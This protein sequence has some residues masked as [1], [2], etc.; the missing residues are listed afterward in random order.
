M[1]STA[2]AQLDA[3]MKTRL[4]HTQHSKLAITL[5]DSKVLGRITEMRTEKVRES[6]K[7]STNKMKTHNSAWT[8]VI[9]KASNE[10]IFL[11]RRDLV[12]HWFD[13][14]T[15]SQR[16]RFFDL[17]FRQCSR[18]QYKFV[19]DWFEEMV[20]LQHLDFTTVLPRFLA[21]Y[22]F[23]FLEPKSLSRCAQV[24]WHW[25]F[26]SE[27]D[28]LWMPKC[29]KYGWFLPY[30]PAMHEYGSWKRHYVGC[31]LTLD[32]VTTNSANNA[33]YGM[34]GDGVDLM[35]KQ[36]SQKDL[37]PAESYMMVTSRPPWIAP[38]SHPKDL[39]KNMYAFLHDFNPND[40]S[41]PKSALLFHNRWGILKKK[42]NVTTSLSTELGLNT[43]RRRERHR[44]LTSGE[45]YDLQ[46]GRSMTLTESMKDDLVNPRERRVNELVNTQWYPQYRTGP[47]SSAEEIVLERTDMSG[48]KATYRDTMRSTRRSSLAG[49]ER[50][51]N[52]RVIFISSRV[53]A[54]ELLLDAVLFGVVPIVYEYEGTTPESLL[55]RLEKALQGRNA[56]SIGIFTHTES[57]GEIRL[58][59]SCN[60]SLANMDYPEAREFFEM[61]SGHILPSGMGGQF[62]IFAPLAASEL[63]MELMVQLTVL[64]GVQFS[65]PTGI[66]G[67]YN[68]VSSDW[69]IPY[70][71]GPPP[72]QYF[73]TSKLNVWANTADQAVES[74]K[75]CRQILAPYFENAHRDVAAQLT[76]EVVF[77]VLGQTDIR[78][79]KS[80]TEALTEALVALGDQNGEN[81]LEFLGQY[82][83][84][85]AGVSD[86]EF[87]STR[88]RLPAIELPEDEMQ[89]EVDEEGTDKT[90]KADAKKP[91]DSVWDSDNDDIQGG[92]DARVARRGED[93][94]EKGTLEGTE[95]SEK[96][97]RTRQRGERQKVVMKTQELSKKF[98]TI[99]ATGKLERLTSHRFREYPEKRTPIAMEIVSSEVDYNRAL[100][101][102]KKV[103][104]KPLNAAL[105]SNR[106]IISNQN[107]QI[108]FTDILAI[109]ENSSELKDNLQSRLLDWDPQQSCLGDIFVKFNSHLKVYTNFINNNEVILRCIERSKE[110]TPA[111]RAFLARHD[112][113]PETKMLTLQ[114][115]LLLPGCR[116]NQYV[117]LLSWFELHTPK[118]HQDRADLANA[119]ETLTELDRCIR[120]CQ[121][122][123]ERDRELIELQRK[124]LNC[125][126]LLEANRYLVKHLDVNQHNPPKKNSDIPELQFFQTAATYGLFLF[127]DALVLTRRTSKHFP[128]SRAIEHNY[129]FEASISLGRLRIHDMPDSKDLTNSFKME[130]PKQ[131]WYFST[132]TA[133]EKHNWVSL[134]EQS[135]RSHLQG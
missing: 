67:N 107:L 123:M 130:N 59:H 114:E 26:L 1:T 62:D 49:T 40:P 83:L 10:Q 45:D 99:R 35:A 82:L 60:V 51:Q 7:F 89:P 102:V 81:P 54:A 110:Q 34:R 41:M 4:R 124:I 31:V 11:E 42:S 27:Q 85:R 23:S 91:G 16:K 73:C 22:I 30:T 12:S 61:A 76:G 32:Y 38:A 37:T 135:I 2:M 131:L 9:N 134:V 70:K 53:P 65:S 8:P 36:P 14:W 29:L 24:C 98:G 117:T 43:Q 121:V 18:K 71:E 129:K 120:E 20:P 50:P 122:R 46:T 101:A 119:I 84:Q 87:T 5:N 90:L 106:G 39:H 74:L 111:F 108:I 55:V 126:A 93:G 80:I 77:G 103:Y 21:L 57:P 127:N 25:K 96:L 69:C 44:A 132:E 19:Q 113:S 66:I 88:Q 104:F 6:G 28:V 64:T 115:L 58:V 112:R 100:T 118:S 68:H 63:G 105:R 92:G 109:L 48:G 133:E 3:N 78:G 86:L 52:P 97:T 72:E 56:Q 47:R 15:D 94:M 13:L 128:F 33:L 125:P 116:I 75:K 95:A 79:V 17:I